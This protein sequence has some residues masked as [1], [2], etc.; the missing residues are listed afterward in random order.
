MTTKVGNV[1]IIENEP[2]KSCTRCKQNTDCRDVL[3]DGKQV[4]FDCATEAEKKDYCNR[5]F[6]DDKAN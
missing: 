1:V 6:G 5:L 2:D 3:G 4:C